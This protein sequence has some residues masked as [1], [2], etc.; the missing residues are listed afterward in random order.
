[1]FWTVFDGNSPLRYNTSLSDSLWVRKAFYGENFWWN[2]YTLKCCPISWIKLAACCLYEVSFSN[3]IPDLMEG[4]SARSCLVKYHLDLSAF[5]VEAFVGV[6]IS[7]IW[8]TDKGAILRPWETRTLP[9]SRSIQVCSPSQCQ[10]YFE[11]DVD[12]KVS[13]CSSPHQGFQAVVEITHNTRYFTKRDLSPKCTEEEWCWF[14][15]LN[16]REKAFFLS[17]LWSHQTTQTLENF[18][19]GG[20]AAPVAL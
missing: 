11:Q 16:Q 10:C 6:C 18:T 13:A 15:L 20:A 7:S 1:M 5:P 14:G 4:V 12:Q 9:M 19:H 3:G 2:A 17:C 8:V